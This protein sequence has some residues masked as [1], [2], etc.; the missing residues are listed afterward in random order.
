MKYLI[1][2]LI[3]LLSSPVLASSQ[4]IDKQQAVEIAQKKF[5]G[6]VLSVKQKGE[7]FH[8]KIL[9]DSGDVRIIRIKTRQDEN[10]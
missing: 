5:P 7:H 3:L 9:N 4:E 10:R 8:V 2:S 6:R 1:L